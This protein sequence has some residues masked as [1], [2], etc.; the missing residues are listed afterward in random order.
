MT[1]N[2]VPMY[3]GELNSKRKFWDDVIK[4]LFPYENEDTQRHLASAAFNAYLQ[5]TR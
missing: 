1:K 2:E 5:I 4:N 3:L